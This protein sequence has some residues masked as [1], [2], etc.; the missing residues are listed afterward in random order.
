MRP[1]RNQVV[2]GPRLLR[3]TKGLLGGFGLAKHQSLVSFAGRHFVLDRWSYTGQKIKYFGLLNFS[4]GKTGEFAAIAG[5]GP[6]EER[7]A[8]FGEKKAWLVEIGVHDSSLSS[9]KLKLLKWM[10][11][12]VSRQ[13]RENGVNVLVSKPS[14][15]EA[16]LFEEMGFKPL[17]NTRYLVFSLGKR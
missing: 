4:K 14:V 13:A 17:E 6:P 3:P 10:C 16:K 11:G 1:K 12:R 8:A 7:L 5:F 2:S 15:D 9:H